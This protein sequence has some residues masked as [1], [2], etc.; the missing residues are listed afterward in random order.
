MVF[1]SSYL[2][3]VKNNLELLNRVRSLRS[4]DENLNALPRVF[5]SNDYLGLSNHPKVIEGAIEATRRYGA[6]SGASRL[7]TG[8]KPIHFELE[9]IISKWKNTEK[10]I[11][12]STGYMTNVGVLSSLL[13]EDAAVYSDEL[14]HAS[15][16]DGIKLSKCEKVT[17]PHCDYDFLRDELK[18]SGRKRSLI[19]SDVVFSMDGD[20]ASTAQLLAIAE[21][22]N[23]LLVLDEAHNVLNPISEACVGH[24]LVLRVGTL[25]KTLGSL[26]GFV[27]GPGSIIDFLINRSRS[28]I[29]STALAPPNV[30]AA[31]KAIEV[32]E[33]QEGENLLEKLRGYVE[34]FRDSLG[35][36]ESHQSPIMPIILGEDERALKASQ[37]L[38]EEGFLVPA[39]RPPSVPVGSSRLRVTLSAA[40][41]NEDVLELRDLILSI[42]ES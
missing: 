18:R 24:P 20:E 33:S 11:L 8:T 39:I 16:V 36:L 19:V 3:E 5:A 13:D 30:G 27:S 32:L 25:S 22:F 9:E 4:V 12:Y 10:S 1:W 23:S 40:N 21:E 37:Q 14:N 17:F 42:L 35:L 29:F 26:G 7:V 38:L 6:S 34:V 28:F 31:I 41:K 15:I 2:D